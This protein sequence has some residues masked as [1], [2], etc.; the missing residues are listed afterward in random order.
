[1]KLVARTADGYVYENPR[2]LPRVLFA[3]AAVKGDFPDMLATGRW[4]QGDVDTTVVLEAPPPAIR[5]RPGTVG[6]TSY[7]H[8][9][10]TVAADSPDGGFVVLNDLWQPWWFTSVDGRPAE[11]LR[12]NV[13]FRAVAV[14]PGRHT[15]TFT[16]RPVAGALAD[17]RRRFLGQ[18]PVLLGERTR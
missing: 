18:S 8:S 10:V 15:V 13:L 11:L 9:E 3:T 6:I 2:A 17:L 4:P 14:P 7:R 12:A 1:L 16:F 5:R